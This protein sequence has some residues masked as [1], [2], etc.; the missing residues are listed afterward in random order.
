MPMVSTA[1]EPELLRGPTWPSFLRVYCQSSRENSPGDKG[2]SISVF[3][4]PFC[5]WIWF[6]FELRTS[7]NETKAVVT[8]TIGGE[9]SP[10][11]L[12]NLCL[13]H[14]GLHNQDLL[15]VGDEAHCTGKETKTQNGPKPQSGRQRL[16]WQDLGP[17]QAYK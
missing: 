9:E 17:P 14:Y 8:V 10:C 11:V 5:I 15:R 16:G 12:G 7:E 1:V 13:P 2:L 3:L 4:F 6:R